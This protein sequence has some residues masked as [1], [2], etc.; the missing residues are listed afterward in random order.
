MR[1]KAQITLGIRNASSV[2]LLPPARRQT[3]HYFAMSEVRSNKI[4]QATEYRPLS[5]G[6]V[7]LL[8]FLTVP[9]DV[10]KVLLCV[11]CSNLKKGARSEIPPHQEAKQRC[12]KYVRRLD[13]T[14]F[15]QAGPLVTPLLAGFV[16]GLVHL[17]L[18][19]LTVSPTEPGI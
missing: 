17:A 4:L 11:C 5:G 13:R 10:A 7:Y 1:K 9:I 19:L 15:L 14:P 16:G 12:F 8:V 2:D 18:S 6:K 3:T